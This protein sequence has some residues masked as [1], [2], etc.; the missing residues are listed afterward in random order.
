MKKLSVRIL[1]SVLLVAVVAVG[2]TLAY[3]MASDSPLLNT[4]ALAE[5]ET[6]IKEPETDT[7]TNKT[8]SVENTGESPV[9]VRARVVIS[10]GDADVLEEQNLITFTYNEEAWQNGGD[11]F[12]YYKGILP[13]NSGE[14][15]ETPA[16]FTGVTVSKDVPK[17]AEFSVDVYQESVLAPSGTGVTWT[18]DAAQAAFE[19]KANP[20]G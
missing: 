18:L 9:Y 15:S 10:G 16:L 12:Y 14:A 19:A 4:F 2:G 7:A 6:E 20:Q 17:E 13:A 11:G 1:L 5:V 3:L 8:A